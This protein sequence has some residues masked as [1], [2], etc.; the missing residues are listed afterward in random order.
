LIVVV[1]KN[2]IGVKKEK[3]MCGPSKYGVN[4]I[5]KIY[6]RNVMIENTIKLLLRDIG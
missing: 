3:K 5:I 4:I 2:V 1:I 6:V